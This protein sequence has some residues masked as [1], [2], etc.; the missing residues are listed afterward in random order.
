MAI[1][2]IFVPYEILY[3]LN[4]DGTVA[5]CHRR[6]LKLIRDDETGEVFDAKELDPQPIDGAAM[7]AVLGVITTA[8]AVTIAQQNAQLLDLQNQLAQV[9]EINNQQ[10]DLVSNLQ[11]QNTQLSSQIEFANDEII[12]LT[13]ELAA[14][15][16]VNGE[17]N[18]GAE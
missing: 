10:A 16:A 2:Q 11:N 18:A 13:A 8:Q 5:G 15:T 14:A 17:V 7:E 1:E 6:D 3:R 12:R 9:T 4:E